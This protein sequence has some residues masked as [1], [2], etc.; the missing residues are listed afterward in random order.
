M[1]SMCS[2]YS[3]DTTD[4]RHAYQSTTLEA[5]TSTTTPTEHVHHGRETTSLLMETHQFKGTICPSASSEPL[6]PSSGGHGGHAHSI[7]PNPQ[8]PKNAIDQLK[9]SSRPNPAISTNKVKKKEIRTGQKDEKNQS[10]C[11]CIYTYTPSPILPSLGPEQNLHAQIKSSHIPH[12]HNP[13]KRIQ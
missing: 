4:N 8:T 3:R 6:N 7:H 1:P 9:L 13:H 12:K 2:N 11:A 5:T 10:P